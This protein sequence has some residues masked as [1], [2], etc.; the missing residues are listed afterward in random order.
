[1]V[2]V[3]LSLRSACLACATRRP[4]E[5]RDEEIR[6]HSPELSWASR[7]RSWLRKESRGYRRCC[8]NRSRRGLG[9]QPPRTTGSPFFTRSLSFPPSSVS[10]FFLSPF[11]F[12][13]FGFV[14]RSARNSWFVFNM[15]PTLLVGSCPAIDS[16]N[17]MP[18][19]G[20]S[21]EGSEWFNGL[22]RSVKRRLMVYASSWC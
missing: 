8:L 4:V 22:G 17:P 9:T 1:M 19:L 12:Y 13:L 7:L 15:T 11:L 5:E 10:L 21:F 20:L 16:A 3:W 14:S 2:V 6:L 18:V